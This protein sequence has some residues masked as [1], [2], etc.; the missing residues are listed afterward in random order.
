[1]PDGRMLKKVIAESRSLGALKTDSARLL[2]TWLLPFLDIEG[3]HTADPEIVKGHIF[4]KVKTMTAPR[5]RTLL[6]DLAA[7]G[8]ITI[9]QVNREPFLQFTQF[10]EHQKLDREREAPSKIPPPPD[11]SGVG[12]EDSRPTPEDSGGAAENSL[13]S[14]SLS[15]DKS[16]DKSS[17]VEL[18]A[19]VIRYLNEKTGKHFLP[20]AAS[21]VKLINASLAEGR[22]LADFKRVIDVKVAQWKGDP[23]MD[24]YLRPDTLFNGEKMEAYVNEAPPAELQAQDREAKR[25]VQPGAH[26]PRTPEQVARDR[27]RKKAVESEAQRLAGEYE[28]RIEA[29]LGA[30]D[31]KEA[32]RLKDEMA[33]QVERYASAWT[34]TQEKQEEVRP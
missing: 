25:A 7:A 23:R 15:K 24:G 31:G 9:Y 21:T 28:P 17:H 33:G 1:M 3:R 18:R 8:L 30:G 6:K 4:P 16:K 34:G 27:A 22:T 13:L 19:E 2:Y 20:D 11:N 29:A 32:R 14:L 5:I 26:A 10:Q 12:H